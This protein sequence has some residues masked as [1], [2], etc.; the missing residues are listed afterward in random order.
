ML[1]NGSPLTNTAIAFAFICGDA[2]HIVSLLNCVRLGITNDVTCSVVAFVVVGRLLL[3]TYSL[4]DA[5]TLM[6]SSVLK[7]F[8][9]NANV[10][11]AVPDDAT[12]V[13]AIVVLSVDS[14]LYGLINFAS[15]STGNALPKPIRLYGL[16]ILLEVVFFLGPC[17]I[18]PSSKSFQS[19]VLLEP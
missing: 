4:S 12:H 10:L 19:F 18:I 5:V 7:L 13:V 16:L 17:L 6:P 2:D 15:A 1:I 3:S 14:I 9:L 11:S 8:V